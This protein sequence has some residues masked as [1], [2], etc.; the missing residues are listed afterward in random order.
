MGNAYLEYQ[1]YAAIADWAERERVSCL[2]AVMVQIDAAPRKMV[3]IARLGE[4][5]GIPPKTLERQYYRWRRFGDVALAAEPMSVDLK[6]ASGQ[7]E[8]PEE[9]AAAVDSSG[10]LRY[11]GQRRK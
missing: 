8:L 6:K 11:K 10:F 7:D 2:A 1:N 3:A 4:A 5:N 9:L